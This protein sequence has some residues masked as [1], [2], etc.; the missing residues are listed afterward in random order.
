M[1]IFTKTKTNQVFVKI[2]LFSAEICFTPS[3]WNKSIRLCKLRFP[4]PQDSHCLNTPL[5][6]HKQ[7]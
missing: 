6:Y 7:K 5:K 2:L 1:Y 3:A 4:P